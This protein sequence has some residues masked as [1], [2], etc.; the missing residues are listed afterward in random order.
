[1]YIAELIGSNEEKVFS[2]VSDLVEYYNKN[3]K[4]DYLV[5]VCE[6]IEDAT[7]QVD[8]GEYMF[9]FRTEDFGHIR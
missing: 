6:A 5:A 9:S 7:G 8:A 3:H 2:S 1:M 4:G